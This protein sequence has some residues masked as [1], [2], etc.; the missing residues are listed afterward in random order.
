MNPTPSSS[1]AHRLER[2]DAYLREDPGNVALLA[3]ACEA[4]IACGEHAR[5]Q[6]YIDSAEQLV[7]DPTEWTFRRAR[8]AIARRDLPTAAQLLERLAADQG[9]HP[10]LAHDLAYVRLLQGDFAACRATLEPWIA[11]GVATLP[12]AQQQALQ[13]LWLRAQHRLDHLE[14]AIQW[15]HAQERSGALSWAAQG[16][17][18]LIALDAGDHE[19]AQRWADTALLVDA[20]QHEA[21]VARGSVALLKGDSEGGTRLLERA[22]AH[23]PD[24]GRTWSSLGIASLQAMRLPEA[25]ARLERAV[26]AMPDHIDSWHALAWA[27]LLQGDRDGALAALRE[28]MAVDPTHADTHAAMGLV[29]ALAGDVAAAASCLGEAERLEP[30]NAT[31][32]SARALLSGSG[33][34]PQAL[35]DVVR[36]MLEQSG[37]PGTRAQD[38][39]RAASRVRAHG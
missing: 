1:P 29:L 11:S 36:R 2:L 5:A 27:R 25:Q 20:S 28:A 7:V 16:V 10:V 14:E 18:S 39:F 17:A 37:L 26:G 23:H 9:P 32:A 4:A 22:L 8:L 38:M 15:S 33:Q 31:A 19:A 3:D 24:D 6:V 30:K 12:P 21:L 13:V 35:Q 34:D